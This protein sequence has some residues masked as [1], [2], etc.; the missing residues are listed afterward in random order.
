MIGRLVESLTTPSTLALII[1]AYVMIKHPEVIE[2][3]T[4]S[5]NRAIANITR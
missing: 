1:A 2:G 3:A 4:H 5:L